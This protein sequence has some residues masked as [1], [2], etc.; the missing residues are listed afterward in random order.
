MKENSDYP[1]VFV[2]DRNHY[3]RRKVAYSLKNMGIIKLMGFETG[4]C[5]FNPSLPQPNLII[6]DY[7]LGLGNWNGL[8]FMQEYNR[9]QKGVNF[10]FLSSNVKIEIAYETIKG[11]AIDY[12]IK[13][14][15]GMERLQQMV[16]N[17]RH[18]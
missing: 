18:C 1:I 8:E 9:I 14:K 4:E 5:C 2:V 16:G 12:I 7:N 10:L 11:G 13:S 3:Y 17:I 6:L 15:P